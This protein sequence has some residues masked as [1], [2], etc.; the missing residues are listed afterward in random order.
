MLADSCIDSFETL[1]PGAQFARR[2]ESLSLKIEQIVATE[3]QLKKCF[4]QA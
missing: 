2:A 4:R 1:E 3:A